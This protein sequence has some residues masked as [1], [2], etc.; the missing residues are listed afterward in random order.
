MRLGSASGFYSTDYKA[1]KLWLQQRDIKNPVTSRNKKKSSILIW[2][3]KTNIFRFDIDVIVLHGIIFTKIRSAIQNWHHKYKFSPP[4][5]RWWKWIKIFMWIRA[6]IRECWIGCREF[7]DRTFHS[8]AITATLSEL[9]KRK[10]TIFLA[11][12]LPDGDITFI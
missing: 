8:N 1:E 12:N 5:H 9:Q 10:S 4:H 6:V 7:L 2:H 3:A 11:K